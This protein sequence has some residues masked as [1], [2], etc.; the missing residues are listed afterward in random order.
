MPSRG[1]RKLL[2]GGPHR[3]GEAM[4]ARSSSATAGKVVGGI[5]GALFV[6]LW[7]LGWS[8]VTLTFDVV[9]VKS[10]LAQWRAASYP[11]AAGTVTSS[12]VRESTDSEGARSFA[13]KVA[14][15]YDVGGRRYECER[16]RHGVMGSGRRPASAVV[17][18]HPPG[19]A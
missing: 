11:T 9:W 5:F 19:R 17:A 6:A 2:V 18:S 13:A 3:G 1:N 14:Y 15:A 16:Y 12:R 8:A 7:V 4:K 10:V